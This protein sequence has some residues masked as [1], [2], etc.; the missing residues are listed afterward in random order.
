MA[1]DSKTAASGGEAMEVDSTAAAAT[2]GASEGDEDSAELE[3]ALAMSMEVEDAGVRCV[4]ALR[5]L[6]RYKV[7]SH[8]E[9]V[10]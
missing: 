3:A 5:C 7:S 9:E 4:L 6:C 10:M 2:A 1:N 8:T